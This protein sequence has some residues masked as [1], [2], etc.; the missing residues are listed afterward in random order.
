[1]EKTVLSGVQIKLI[2]IIKYIFKNP[3]K[4]K[5]LNSFFF[6]SSYT[7]KYLNIKK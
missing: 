4:Y 3:F 6:F 5:K 2:L 1:M 7:H